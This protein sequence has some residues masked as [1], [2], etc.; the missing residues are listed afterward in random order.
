MDPRSDWALGAEGA[1]LPAA[2]TAVSVSEGESGAGERG[3][4]RGA[5]EGDLE[6]QGWGTGPDGGQDRLGT[7]SVLGG[8]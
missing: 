3:R 2:G 5:G 7:S 6:S 1:V 4:E 8:W